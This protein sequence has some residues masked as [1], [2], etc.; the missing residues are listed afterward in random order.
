MVSMLPRAMTVCLIH[1]V[2]TTIT[3]TTNLPVALFGTV[4]K[5]IT[6]QQP[7]QWCQL[8]PK[9]VNVLIQKQLVLEILNIK[10]ILVMWLAQICLLV[11]A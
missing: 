3:N 6:I 7:K 8:K 1:T 4:L 10:T 2:I 11:N 9:G 5:T